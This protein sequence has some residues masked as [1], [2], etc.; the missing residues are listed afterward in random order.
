MICKTRTEPRP[1][2]VLSLH[3]V[4]RRRNPQSGT[5][6]VL[7]GAR[8]PC[9]YIV[10]QVSV[11]RHRKSTLLNFAHS[12]LSRGMQQM[13][14]RREREFSETPPALPSKFAHR[15]DKQLIR[16]CKTTGVFIPLVGS[17][18]SRWPCYSLRYGWI[19]YGFGEYSS[20]TGPSRLSGPA[21]CTL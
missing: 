1:F 18:S 7:G 21:K 19:G 16:K 10:I 4:I 8:N 2:G 17:M 14:C 12:G 9:A 20:S 5:S 6:T 13:R 15:T 3:S 11:L